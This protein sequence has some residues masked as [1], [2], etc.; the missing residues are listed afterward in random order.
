MP[1][2]IFEGERRKKTLYIIISAIA[3]AAVATIVVI[4]SSVLANPSNGSPG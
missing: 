2:R 1:L 3:I 4:I